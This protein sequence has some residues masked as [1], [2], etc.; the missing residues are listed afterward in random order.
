MRQPQIPR[1]FGLHQWNQH[2]YKL[3]DPD[4]VLFLLSLVHC[5]FYVLQK[6]LRI[7][8]NSSE[9]SRWVYYQHQTAHPWNNR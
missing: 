4:A 8:I 2:S 9:L 5:S 3:Q 6:I 7:E 1:A